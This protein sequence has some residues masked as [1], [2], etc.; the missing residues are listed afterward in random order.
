MSGVVGGW[1]IELN[2]EEIESGGR[3]RKSGNLDRYKNKMKWKR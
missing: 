1:K 3:K 2:E